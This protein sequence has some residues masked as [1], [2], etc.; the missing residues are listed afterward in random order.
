M[1]RIAPA[2]LALSLALLAGCTNE[3]VNPI[4]REAFEQVRA[5]TG[6]GAGAG[7]AEAGGAPAGIT[8]AD[9]EATGTAAIRARALADERGSLLYAVTENAG[10]TTY[11]S[12]LR[13]QLMLR[14]NQ[15]AATR[16]LGTDL[17]AATSSPGDPLVQPTP[18]GAWPARVERRFEFP[19]FAARGRIETYECTFTMGEVRTIAI[20]TV[21][22]RG[23][24][25]TE[26]CTGAAGSFEN[27]HFADLSTGF[28]WRSIQWS[29][30]DQGSIDIEIIVP[31]R[32]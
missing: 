17:L 18:P 22:H 12:Q 11:A 23:V 14:G 16:G 30:P 8:R 6:T 1:R 28:V 32:R 26:T 21:Q 20:L 13:Q 24:E 9:I 29:G 3:G 5:R 15:L 2:A 4:A 31:R 19:A 10:V 25:I 7:A 27:L